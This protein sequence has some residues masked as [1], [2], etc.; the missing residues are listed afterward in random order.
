MDAISKALG[1]LY[2]DLAKLQADAKTSNGAMSEAS[3]ARGVSTCWSFR[4]REGFG[5]HGKDVYRDSKAT[6]KYGKA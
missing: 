4:F 3:L 1:A 2:D 6:S 5:A